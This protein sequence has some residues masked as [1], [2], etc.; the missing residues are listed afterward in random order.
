MAKIYYK[1]IV[2]KA[3]N[4]ATGEEWKLEDVPTKWRAEVERML[5]N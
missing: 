2:E 4:P 1:K 5:E 3:I